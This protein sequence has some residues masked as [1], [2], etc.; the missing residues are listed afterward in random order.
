MYQADVLAFIDENGRYVTR[1]DARTKFPGSIAKQIL[2][3]PSGYG[4][5]A[6]GALNFIK[7]AITAAEFAEILLAALGSPELI[8]LVAAVGLTVTSLAIL[9]YCSIPY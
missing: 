7:N 8:L 4:A 5:A 9:I 2:K 3:T 6:T 1:S